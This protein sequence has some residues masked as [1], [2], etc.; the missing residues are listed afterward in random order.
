INHKYH[1][2]SHND[3][4]AWKFPLNILISYPYFNHIRFLSQFYPDHSIIV[5]NLIALLRK[6][7]TLA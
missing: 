6:E 3:P 5:S 7:G 2:D 4:R 1:L